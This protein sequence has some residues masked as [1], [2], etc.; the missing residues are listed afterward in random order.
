MVINPN[1]EGI[2][3]FDFDKI[4]AL[5]KRGEKAA[6]QHLPKIKKICKK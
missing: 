6:L 3:L 4:K 1:M 2:Q 5:V